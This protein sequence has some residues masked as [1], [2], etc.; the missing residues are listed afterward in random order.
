MKT[1]NIAKCRSH[2]TLLNV[3]I[4][5]VPQ[6]LIEA[7]SDMVQ[8]RR[9]RQSNVSAQEKDHHNLL[10][11]AG[12]ETICSNYLLKYTSTSLAQIGNLEDR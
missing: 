12:C 7:H 3:I 8:L 6:D 4:K 10:Q 9:Q 11:H 1:T 5:S 2:I